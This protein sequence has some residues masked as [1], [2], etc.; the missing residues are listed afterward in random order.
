MTC[1]PGG[2]FNCLMYSIYDQVR[3]FGM[4]LGGRFN[5]PDGNKIVL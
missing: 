5:R 3:A 1:T 4:K 2:R